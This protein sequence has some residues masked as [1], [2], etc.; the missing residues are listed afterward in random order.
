VAKNKPLPNKILVKMTERA[1]ML[2]AQ[3]RTRPTWEAA[4]AKMRS[5]YF[6]AMLNDVLREYKIDSDEWGLYKS[7]L[8]KW[9]QKRGMKKRAYQ[10]AE[11]AYYADEELGTKRDQAL[12][13]STQQY[14]C[15]D[16][17]ADCVVE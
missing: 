10:A 6:G 1:S 2:Y 5:E 3:M 14:P 11:I 12:S 16:Y 7:I 15:A 13:S 8:G 9:L 17:W 4:T